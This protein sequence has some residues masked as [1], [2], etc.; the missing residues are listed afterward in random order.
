MGFLAEVFKVSPFV[1]FVCSDCLFRSSDRRIGLVLLYRLRHNVVPQ[2]QKIN[3][4]RD[5]E[6]AL[7]IHDLLL[8]RLGIMD[9]FIHSFVVH[10]LEIPKLIF[11]L[12]FKRICIEEYIR[13]TGVRQ[14]LCLRDS[15]TH[16]ASLKNAPCI[17]Q[18]LLNRRLARGAENGEQICRHVRLHQV[19]TETSSFTISPAL[20]VL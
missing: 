6:H 19:E 9:L 8:I 2:V 4:L 12:G 15:R 10:I 7:F 18:R 11:S 5:R 16:G 14:L 1:C 20:H 13:T 17:I 3:L